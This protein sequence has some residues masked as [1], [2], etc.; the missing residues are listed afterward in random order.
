MADKNKKDQE[1]EKEPVCSF[2]G[3][4]ADTEQG[5]ILFREGNVYICTD[6]AEQC[7][8]TARKYAPKPILPKVDGVKLNVKPSEIEAFLDEY[9]VGQDHVKQVLS[10][11]VYNHHKLLRSKQEGETDVEIEKSNVMMLGPTGC[12]RRYVNT[13]VV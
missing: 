4:P 6:C 9:V 12:G 2:C 3:L 10:V 7:V 1:Q 5:N 13:N 8:R 11:A